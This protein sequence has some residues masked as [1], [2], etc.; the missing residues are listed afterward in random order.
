MEFNVRSGN[1]HK[2]VD[3][4]DFE[5]SVKLFLQAVIAENDNPKLGHLIQVSCTMKESFFDTNDALIDLGV[6]DKKMKVYTGE[7]SD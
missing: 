4:K 6:S 2:T 7:Q 5:H 1:H 3:A